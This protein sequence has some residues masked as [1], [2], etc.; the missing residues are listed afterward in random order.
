[1]LIATTVSAAVVLASALSGA[2]ASGSTAL[3]PMTISVSASTAISP[4]LVGY[5]LAE[6]DAVWRAAGLSLRWRRDADACDRPVVGARGSDAAACPPATLRVVIGSGHTADA[7]RRGDTSMA[8]G[9]ITFDDDAPASE[10]YLSYDN[11]VAYITNA[12]EVVGPTGRMPVME[13]EILLGR[14]MGRA[15]AHELG[16]Y[17][18]AS[19]THTRRG[20]MRATHTASEFFASERRAFVVDAGQRQTVAD[21]LRQNARVAMHDPR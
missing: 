13:R 16:H 4:S 19:K 2:V 3:P 8:L 9:W 14:A 7:A 6:T 5:L 20:L 15:L 18:L 21:R 10:I 12:R 1:M 17:L 11:A